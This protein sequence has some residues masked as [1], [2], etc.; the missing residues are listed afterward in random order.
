MLLQKAHWDKD[1]FDDPEEAEQLAEELSAFLSV[2]FPSLAAEQGPTQIAYVTRIR[3]R[4]DLTDFF[5]QETGDQELALLLTDVAEKIG[6]MGYIDVRQGGSGNPY[7]VEYEHRSDEEL[8]ADRRSSREI[9]A[10]A[11][12]VETGTQLV[13][14]S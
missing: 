3:S 8:A 2:A 6:K 1:N 7:A 5:Q 13:L 12:N 10:G 9:G 4:K 14:A 11:R